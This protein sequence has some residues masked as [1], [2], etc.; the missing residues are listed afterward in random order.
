VKIIKIHQIMGVIEITDK[1]ES[2]T[3]SLHHV[4]NE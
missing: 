2:G 1:Q 3:A 4:W